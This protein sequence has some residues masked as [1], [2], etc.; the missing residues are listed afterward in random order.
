[1]LVLTGA[2]AISCLGADAADAGGRR[3]G[4]GRAGRGGPA[5]LAPRSDFEA[6]YL[7]WNWT[8]KRSL[9]ATQKGNA[10]GAQ[11][12]L[13]RARVTWYQLLFRYWDDPPP[14]FAGDESWR[15]E[16][17]TITGHLHIAESLVLAGKMYA[18][19][20]ALEPIRR[21]WLDMRGRSDISW[22]GDELTRYHDVMEPLVVW[23]TGASG[24]WVT[25]ESIAEFEEA[26]TELASA[27]Y[28]VTRAPMPRG[29]TRQFSML[30]RQ[31]GKAVEDLDQAIRTR[32]WG[33]IPEVCEELRQAFIPLFMHF[34]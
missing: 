26:Y 3:G 32:N 18:A 2:L 9:M 7:E 10:E 31:E 23:G 4:R 28:E 15:R 6:A 30:V 20:D 24:R 25:P 14:A 19:H 12:A 17:A 33:V 29:N 34:G 16:L 21:V 11:G 1:M 5:I 22:F 13:A 27:W 8:Y